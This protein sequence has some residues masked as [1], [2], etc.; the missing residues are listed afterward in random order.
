[1]LKR[2]TRSWTDSRGRATG[3]VAVLVV[4]DDGGV[5]VLH[6]LGTTRLP[7]D[8]LVKRQSINR[9]TYRTGGSPLIVSVILSFISYD[10]IYTFRNLIIKKELRIQLPKL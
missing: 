8:D 6:E 4:V 10:T 9:V 2:R 1:M 5:R 3:D 7:K